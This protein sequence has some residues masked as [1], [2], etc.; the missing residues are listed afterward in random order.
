[1]G[2]GEQLPALEHQGQ[3]WALTTISASRWQSPMNETSKTLPSIRK[4]AAA[5]RK[6]SETLASE[7][8]VPT[9]ETPQWTEFDWNIT[10]A[11]TAM[12]GVSSLLCDRLRWEGPEIWRRFLYEQ[13]DQ[14]LGR[15]GQ[16]ARLLDAIDSHAQCKGVAII[17]LKGAALRATGMY[18]AGERPMGDIDLLIREGAGDRTSAR[19]LR[20]HNGV[21]TLRHQVFQPKAKK[22][23]PGGSLREHVDNPIKIE[24]HTRI[25]ENFPVMATDITQFLFPR[26]THA[27]LNGYPSVSFI[28]LH[29]LLHAAGNCG[30]PHSVHSV[31]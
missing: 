22:V 28:M 10:R 29:V 12:Q 7:L 20:L 1:M 2:Y 6:N 31:G 17:A 9:S 5:L 25:A 15:H 3:N 4:V 14:S 24:V 26:V 23:T 11:V 21:T 30:L 27:G 13:R 16:V 19:R 8:A 18:A